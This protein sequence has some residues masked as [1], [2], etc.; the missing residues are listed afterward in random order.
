MGIRQD[1]ESE[2]NTPGWMHDCPA[3]GHEVWTV[4]DAE[5]A[6]CGVDV[7][8]RKYLPDVWYIDD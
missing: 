6:F 3:V 8:G 5:C 1:R 2:D 4:Q 7:D